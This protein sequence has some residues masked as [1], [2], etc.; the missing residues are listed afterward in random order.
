MRQEEVATARL[1]AATLVPPVLLRVE[2]GGHG[3]GDSLDQRVSELADIS[4]FLFD[5]FG[6]DALQWSS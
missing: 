3:L 6:F 2:S 5:R 4:A 1:Q